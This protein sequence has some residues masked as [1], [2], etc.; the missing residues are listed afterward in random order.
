MSEHT[1]EDFPVE[2]IPVHLTGPVAIIAEEKEPEDFSVQTIIIGPLST[3]EGPRQ[4]LG[5]DIL[6]KDALIISNDAPI[7]LCHTGAQALSPRNQASG[8][9]NP[10]GF[11]AGIGVGVE[12]TGT[13]PLWAAAPV[14]SRVSVAVNRRQ[15]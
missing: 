8:L 10:D 3:G 13:G 12:L 7:V 15:P 9:P 5:Q 11:Y 2:S 6:R 14:N 1:D 4:I